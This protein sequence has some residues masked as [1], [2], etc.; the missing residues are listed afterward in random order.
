MAT[1]RP[2][3]RTSSLK[4]AGQDASLREITRPEELA[5]RAVLEAIRAGVEFTMND[6]RADLDRLEVKPTMRGALMRNAVRDGLVEQ[7]TLRYRGEDVPV[8]MPSS[9]D[10]A[11]SDRVNLYRRCLT[12]TSAQPKPSVTTQGTIFE[13][14]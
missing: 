8:T 5:F 9:L 14:D 4:N 7:V 11:H 10:A 1:D 3:I 13:E 6:V 12:V 2:S